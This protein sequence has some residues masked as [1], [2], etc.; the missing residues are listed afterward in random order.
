[1]C[2]ENNIEQLQKETY[3]KRGAFWTNMGEVSPDVIS[4]LINPAFTGGPRWPSLRQAF[5]TLKL[6]NGNI[7]IASDGLSDPFDNAAYATENGFEVEFYVETDEPIINDIKDVSS[8]KNSWQFSLVYQMSQTAADNGQLKSVLD[9]YTYVSTELYD[10]T[11][12]LEYKN[13]EGRVGV[14]LGIPSETVGS[15]IVLPL[16]KTKVVSVVL[17]T[18][19]ELEYAVNNGADGRKDLAN[20]LIQTSGATSSLKRSSLI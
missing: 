12:P 13:S 1:M 3:Q 5:I 17:L 19:K 20:K 11:V 4:H 6:P 7:V 2:M 14:L 9:K 16:S 18:L 10:V 15:K 8:I